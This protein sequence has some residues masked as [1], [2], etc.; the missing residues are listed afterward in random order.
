MNLQHMT[1]MGFH[2][3][4]NQLM[5]LDAG[6]D[7]QDAFIMQIHSGISTIVT[8][9]TGLGVSI[10][11]IGI[12]VGGLM[13]MTAFGNERKIFASNTAI[14]CAVIG[15]VIVLLG[16]TFGNSI[17]GWFHVASCSL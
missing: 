10:A 9:L 3:L 8:L 12:I 17:P 11:I 5:P 14:T 2:M 15:L 16:V 7:C 4:A 13:R 6:P 1:Q